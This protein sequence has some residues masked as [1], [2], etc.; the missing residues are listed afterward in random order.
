MVV[1]GVGGLALAG[2]FRAD[3]FYHV[4]GGLCH[5]S[6]GQVY[7]RNGDILQTE[8][9]VAR[10]AVE[11]YVAVV[12]GLTGGMAELVAHTLAAVINLVQQMILIEKGQGAEYAGLVNRVNLILKFGHSDGAVTLSQRLKYQ[13]PVCRGLY[14]V[15]F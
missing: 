5:E 9:A 15:L 7:C 3:A 11:M 12:I 6:L 2:A 4:V 8:C 10:L 13:Q 14:P 1:M